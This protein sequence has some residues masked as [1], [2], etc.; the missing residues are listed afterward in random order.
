MAAIEIV[1][2]AIGELGDG[3]GA[4]VT[5]DAVFIFVHDE[6]KIG[7]IEMFVELLIELS[8]AIGVGGIARANKATE[9]E[10]WSGRLLGEEVFVFEERTGP[11]NDFIAAAFKI[12]TPVECTFVKFATA[13]DN[14][15]FHD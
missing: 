6:V 5:F 15:F 10:A 3:A 8:H 1:D 7:L 2:D 13:G 9:R 14:E 4:D 11:V 12:A